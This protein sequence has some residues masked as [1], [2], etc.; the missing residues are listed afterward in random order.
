M[1]LPEFPEREFLTVEQVADRWGKYADHVHQLVVTRKIPQAFLLDG[2]ANVCQVGTDGRPTP[3]PRGAPKGDRLRVLVTTI[4]TNDDLYCW[5]LAQ[6][7]HVYE[8]PLDGYIDAWNLLNEARKEREN[9][10][11]S[12][13]VVFERNATA[14]HGDKSQFLIAREDVEK[15]ERKYGQV[16]KS[17]QEQEASRQKRNTRMIRCQAIADLI[18]KSDPSATLEDV[19]KDERIV[20]I[21]CDGKPPSI[22]TFQDWMKGRN[23]NKPGRPR[24]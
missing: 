6:I 14:M 20:R 1:P 5:P 19:L 15:F 12:A 17:P 22:R 9:K 16:E 11:T 24:G 23:P 3:I 8:A 4:R 21:A 2:R 7:L 10:K 18:W 13:F